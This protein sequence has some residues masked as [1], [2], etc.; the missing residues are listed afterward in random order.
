MLDF[1]F[2]ILQCPITKEGLT[3]LSEDDANKI[4]SEYDTEFLKLV[5]FLKAS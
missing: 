4:T 3:L 5:I 2:S 1:D